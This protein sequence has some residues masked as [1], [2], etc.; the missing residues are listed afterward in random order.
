MK[1]LR[2]PRLG[3]VGSFAL[4]SAAAVTVLGV[5]L[6]RVE[7]SHERSH[8]QEEAAASAELL[9]QVGLQPNIR[10]SDITC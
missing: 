6:A 8:A 7:A 5:A 3:F 1:R 9:V 4:L 2:A 10:R